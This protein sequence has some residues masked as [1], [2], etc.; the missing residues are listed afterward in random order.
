MLEYRIVPIRTSQGTTVIDDDERLDPIRT[1][2]LTCTRGGD[3]LWRERVTGR[4]ALLAGNHTF[5]AMET[6][7]GELY[8][9]TE[10]GR[11]MFGPMVLPEPLAFLEVCAAAPVASA[12]ATDLT[13]V[14]NFNNLKNHTDFDMTFWNWI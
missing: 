2:V 1:T 3:I 6:T 10:V 13:N 5:C 7:Y 8:L 14:N 12:A 11:R 9:F 4:A